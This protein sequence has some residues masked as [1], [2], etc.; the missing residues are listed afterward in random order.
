MITGELAASMTAAA[1][2]PTIIHRLHQC[3]VTLRLAFNDIST[4]MSIQVEPVYVRTANG[5]K[6]C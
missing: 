4:E 3:L 1:Q 5:Q 2:I 6:M